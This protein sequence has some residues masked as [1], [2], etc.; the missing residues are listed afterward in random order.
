M[1]EPSDLD[2]ITELLV[3]QSTTAEEADLARMVASF[4]APVV[5]ARAML[6]AALA[7]RPGLLDAALDPG[8]VTVIQAPDRDWGVEIAIAWR[9]LVAPGKAADATDDGYGWVET[10]KLSKA[11]S[12][13]PLEILAFDAKAPSGRKE[14]DRNA[15]F[16]LALRDSRP[17]YA[18][19]QDPQN[20]L[21][22]EVVAAADQTLVVGR[23]T[24]A[25]L[26]AVALELCQPG[27]APIVGVPDDVAREVRATDLVVAARPGQTADAM[28]RRIERMVRA[29]RVPR[30]PGLA[31]LPG[32]GAATEWAARLVEDLRSCR[33]GDLGAAELDRGAVLEGP[34]GC[35]KTSLAR[36]IADSAEV[37][38]VSA[39]LQ[40]WQGARDGH[41]GTTL[42]AM[43]ETFAQARRL[44]PCVLLVDELDSLGDRGRFD[45][46]HRDYSR[47]VVNG[48]LEQLDGAFGRTGVVVIGCT[49]D[50]SHLDPAIVRSGRLERLIRVPLPDEEGL[51]AIFW[52]HLD[53]ALPGIEVPEL[54]RIA[55][56]RRA[57]GADVERWCRSARGTA[58]RARRPMVAEDLL[59]EVGTAPPPPFRQ[60]LWLACVHEAGHALGYLSLGPG[61]LGS[62]RI[63]P[64]SRSLGFTQAWLPTDRT[65]VTRAVLHGQLRALLA[66]RAAEVEVLGEASSGSGGADSSDL[67]VATRLAVMA[68]ASMGLDEHP[69]A[70]LWQPVGSASAADDILARD[71]E[72]R[73]RAAG[74]LNTAMEDARRLVQEHLEGTVVVAEALMQRNHLDAGE[75]A[76]LLGGLPPWEGRD[77]RTDRMPNTEGESG[78]VV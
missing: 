73:R 77:H 12:L 38:F 35:G 72:V 23:P 71:G 68:V 45:A 25:I 60:D 13:D 21:A 49:N 10:A 14:R 59:A 63:R 78:H 64:E 40:D 67:A 37:P 50:A 61:V 51:Q 34:P 31:A 17:V 75:V 46:R 1:T 4:G 62:V 70:L 55:H 44:A 8:T 20:L 27:V 41:L 6:Q 53:G 29:R 57:A 54:A 76:S 15:T 43:Q 3:E 9:L 30:G 39:S 22:P 26:T 48:F 69:H 33:V 58:R 56:A 65:F 32:M 42:G 52:H 74:L 16:R 7:T 47:Q 19:S 11:G 18:I 36:A 24:P 66:G 2:T 28:L 5:V